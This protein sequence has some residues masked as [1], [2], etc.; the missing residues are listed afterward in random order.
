M[1]QKIG[2][3]RNLLSVVGAQNPLKQTASTLLA[4]DKLLNES[5]WSMGYHFVSVEK[6]GGLEALMAELTTYVAAQAK[7]LASA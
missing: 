5:I 1:T 4:A 7:V 6:L 2:S 3:R